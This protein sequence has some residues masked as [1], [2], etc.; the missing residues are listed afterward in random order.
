MIGDIRLAPIDGAEALFAQ[1]HIVKAD[2]RPALG[3]IAQA[4]KSRVASRPQVLDGHPVLTAHA[5][6]EREIRAR[7]VVMPAVARAGNPAHEEV[8]RR[9]IQRPAIAEDQAQREQ[10][11]RR[12]AIVIVGV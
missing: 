3:K 6:G 4:W 9:R 10:R 11:L 2:R 8:A 1:V 7:D 12:N 5:R